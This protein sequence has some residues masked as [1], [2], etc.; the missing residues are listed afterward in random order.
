MENGEVWGFGGTWHKKTGDRNPKPSP[1]R[2]FDRV[3]IVKIGCGD[4]HSAALSD[5]GILFTWGGGGSK[6]NKGQLGHGI[7]DDVQT[8]MPIKFFQNSPIY[9]FECGGYHTV[10]I[11]SDGEVFAW[12]NGLYGQLGN[13]TFED[14]TLPRRVEFETE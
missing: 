1:I 8:P 7:S 11:Q 10:S 13:G 12:G 5:Q 6:Y 9:D 14:S 2:G 3:N 4:F